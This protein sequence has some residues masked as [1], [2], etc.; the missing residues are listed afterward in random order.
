MSTETV[1]E[2]LTEEEE[3]RIGLHTQEMILNMG[4]SHPAT[5]GTVKFTLRL[6]GETIRDLDPDIGYLHRGFEKMCENATYTHAFPYTDRLNYCSPFINNVGYALAVE[7]LLGIEI[8][9][10]CKYVRTIISE[11][12]RISDHLTCLAATSLELGAFT[13]FL[14]G[15]QSREE[16][17]VLTE[18]ICGARLTVSYVRIGGLTDDLPE[19][20]ADHWKLVKRR[21]DKNLYDID[22]LIGRNRIF[23]DRMQNTGILDTET[24]ISYGCTGP[25]LRACG[26]EYDVRDAAP[27]LVY[28]RLDWTMPTGTRGDNWD[29]FLIRL[30]EI[31]QSISMIDQCIEQM[32]EGPVRIDD[33]RVVLP[34][35]DEVYNS[36]EAMMA[37]FKL[38]MEGLKVP[39]GEVYSYTE[40]ANGELGF[41]I[42]SDGSGKPSRVHVRPPCYHLVAA[43]P[44]IM[45]GKLIQDLVPT[46][47]TINMIGGEIDR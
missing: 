1:R 23:I 43:L 11:L 12:H 27:Y 14:Y 15:V 40:G 6:E 28:D 41:F 7:K 38:I 47:D 33:W 4:P 46:F 21:L 8:T 9:E 42:V 16:I 35:K 25:F 29:R 45:R 36:I 24:A 10:R 32:P 3:D 34:P 17:Y 39:P 19:S 13:V 2:Y 20:F 26:V 31:E 44:E 30:A 18:E 5:H 37:H 22:K